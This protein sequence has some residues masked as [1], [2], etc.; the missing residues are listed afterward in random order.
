[1]MEVC[2]RSFSTWFMAH[3]P[4]LLSRHPAAGA[5]LGR[6]LPH[7][8]ADQV[9]IGR[10]SLAPRT[11]SDSLQESSCIDCC[12]RHAILLPCCPGSTPKES[13]IDMPQCQLS[14]PDWDDHMLGA[15]A[16]VGKGFNPGNSGVTL[17]KALKSL[18]RL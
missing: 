3:A 7:F 16:I 5:T 9:W 6:F 14:A 8:G 17:Q 11:C 1:V 18:L 4:E 10:I 15:E 2:S 13:G 12:I